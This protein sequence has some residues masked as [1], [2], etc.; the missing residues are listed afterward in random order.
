LFRQSVVEADLAGNIDR[1]LIS[2]NALARYFVATGK[3]EDGKAALAA[4]AELKD[5]ISKAML[6]GEFRTFSDIFARIMKLKDESTR[7]AQNQRACGGTS[8]R[9]KL[10]DLASLAAE[11]GGV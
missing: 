4:E 2:Y 5:A 10:D 8:F 1:D 3:E 7:V 9:Y 11:A 6:E